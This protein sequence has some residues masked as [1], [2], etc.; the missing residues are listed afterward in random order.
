MLKELFQVIKT[1]KE[2][3]KEAEGLLAYIQSDLSSSREAHK[4]HLNRYFYLLSGIGSKVEH[5]FCEKEL[6]SI[7]SL[8]GVDIE[9]N[10]SKCPS[11]Q[12]YKV[13]SKND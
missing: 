4:I 10:S 5:R 7:W 9:F 2:C 8:R 6:S 13:L 12:P 1:V 3:R 11:G